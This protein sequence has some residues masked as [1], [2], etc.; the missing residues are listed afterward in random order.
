MKN[1]LSILLLTVFLLLLYSKNGFSQ[2]TCQ[3]FTLSDFQFTTPCV[4]EYDNFQMELN[5]F[6]SSTGDYLSNEPYCESTFPTEFFKVW[7]ANITGEIPIGCTLE[8][9]DNSTCCSSVSVFSQGN[10]VSSSFSDNGILL[11]LL[12]IE[13]SPVDSIVIDD[14]EIGLVENEERT[15]SIRI[16]CP[17][18]NS[19]CNSDT[20]ITAAVIPDGTQVLGRRI[21][22]NGL[23]QTNS[24]V[25]FEA[26][27]SIVFK[28]G[29]TAQNRSAFT[30]RIV[31]CSPFQK[32]QNTLE[33]RTF[34]LSDVDLTIFPNPAKNHINLSFSLLE[35][36]EVEISIRDIN[37]R[38]I[39]SKQEILPEGVNLVQFDSSKLQKG[40]YVAQLRTKWGVV[41]KQII[42]VE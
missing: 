7:L 26:S 6:F 10:L 25:L 27:E 36:T 29:F 38:E 32:Q 33:S 35:S 12:T 1:L 31:A 13:D 8:I 41:S 37:S 14:I 30:A 20:I 4:Y 34:P 22:A 40:I 9:F 11:P 15:I 18:S 42:I 21:T 16:C 23:V 3:T 19:D 28:T 5:S 24:N 2:T 39:L 17:L